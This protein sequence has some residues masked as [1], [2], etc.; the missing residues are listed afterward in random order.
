MDDG[1]ANG[2][3]VQHRELQ[4]YE[5]KPFNSYFPK[6]II[7]KDGGVSSG[8]N[9]VTPNDFSEIQRLLPRVSTISSETLEKYF[10]HVEIHVESG[11]VAKT[12]F[13]VP[14]FP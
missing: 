8:F 1:V 11:F 3:A 4:N 7:Y 13:A 6:G 12:L 2:A 14:R 9:H 5:S 10:F